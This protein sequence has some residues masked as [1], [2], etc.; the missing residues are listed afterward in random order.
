MPKSA[1]RTAY[2]GDL[3]DHLRAFGALAGVIEVGSEKAYARAASDVGLDVSVLR[4]RMQTLSDHV[5]AP[6]VIGRGSALRLTPAGTR[7]RDQAR[8]MLD[9]AASI[10]PERDDDGPLRIACTGTFHSEI[11]PTVLASMRAE[12]PHLR[13]RVRRAG[14]EASLD[15]LRRDDLD[16]AIVRSAD[17]PKGVTARH[18][19]VDR[20]WLAVPKQS[21]LAAARRPSIEAMAKEP[22]IGYASTSATMRRLMLVL[23][24]HGAVP[25]IEVDGKT[26]ALA[27]VAVGLGIAFVSLLA[28]QVPERRG[29][30]VRDVTSLFPRV[31]FWLVWPEHMRLQ[32]FRKTFVDRVTSLG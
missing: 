17:A 30:V 2:P 8:R 26:A 9:L 23:A 1:G 20:L 28:G 32:G 15:L 10:R 27:Y 29:V 6:L 13:F 7:V 21:P 11:L 18:I 14:A 3:L 19:G 24:P 5:G 22:I 31:S 16:L 4:R 25:W 12:H